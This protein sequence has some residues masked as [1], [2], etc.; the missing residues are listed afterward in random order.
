MGIIKA[1]TDFFAKRDAD[2]V[3]VASE[4]PT[5]ETIPQE[6]IKVQIG[7]IVT[8][9]ED[10]LTGTVIFGDKDPTTFFRKEMT[11]YQKPVSAL[12]STICDD[13]DFYRAL[14]KYVTTEFI[15]SNT[16]IPADL[17]AKVREEGLFIKDDFVPQSQYDEQMELMHRI[18]S[19]IEDA[20]IDHTGEPVYRVR[21][22]VIHN[23]NIAVW[24][25][26]APNSNLNFNVWR[27]I[28][29]Q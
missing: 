6:E 11:K 16:G 28:Q 8:T 1:W 5:E 17:S 3:V 4:V 10:I 27:R 13:K 14:S 21:L 23:S 9:E 26:R 18:Y 29:C 15:Y 7:D 2:A 25:S 19:R 24:V 20:I 22:E 12:L